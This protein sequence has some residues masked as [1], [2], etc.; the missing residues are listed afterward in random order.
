MSHDWRLY[1]D[2]IAERAGRVLEY[3]RGISYDEF[4]GD[5]RTYDA[6]LR[7]LEII[8]EAAK[9]VPADTRRR[10]PQVPWREISRETGSRTATAPWMTG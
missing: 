6:T 9:R 8:G 2:D 3:T 7:N 10:Y 1:L 5:T 4:V